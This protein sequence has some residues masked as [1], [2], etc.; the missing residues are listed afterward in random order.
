MYGHDL[1]IKYGELHIYYP[2]KFETKQKYVDVCKVI[3]QSKILF[4]Q[5][6]QEKIMDA[7]GCSLSQTIDDIKK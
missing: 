4:S 7:L 6:Y 5:E 2:L 3:E 1:K